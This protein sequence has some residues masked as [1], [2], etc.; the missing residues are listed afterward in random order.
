MSVL[1][2]EIGPVYQTMAIGN[3]DSMIAVLQAIV[4]LEKRRMIAE[5]NVTPMVDVI[6]VLLIIFMV[7]A[8]YNERGL[9]CSCQKVILV[10]KQ[11]SLAFD[12][13]DGH[14]ML[15]DE[16]MDIDELKREYRDFGKSVC[17]RY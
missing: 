2:Y 11:S 10:M 16:I 17:S 6:L 7:T 3:D 1:G 9:R 12:F 14:F 13:F 15:N 8:T 5:I 4:G